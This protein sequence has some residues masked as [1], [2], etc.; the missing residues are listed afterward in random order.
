MEIQIKELTA[1]RSR[2]ETLK[3]DHENEIKENKATIENLDNIIADKNNNIEE[4]QRKDF[5]LKKLL[6][7]NSNICSCL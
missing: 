4:L 2:L 5:F 1:E 6:W 7:Y 3:A